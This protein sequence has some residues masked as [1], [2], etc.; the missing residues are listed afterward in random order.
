MTRY[1]CSFSYTYEYTY[2][3]THIHIYI[4]MYL[5]WL[6]INDMMKNCANSFHILTKHTK[7]I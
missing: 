5:I 7:E 2:R 4:Y 1:A 6:L 3:Y